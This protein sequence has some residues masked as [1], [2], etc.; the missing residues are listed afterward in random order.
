MQ[1]A[2]VFQPHE[3]YRDDQAIAADFGNQVQCGVN[4]QPQQLESSARRK[5][6]LKL[7]SLRRRRTAVAKAPAQPPKPKPQPP[8]VPRMDIDTPPQMSAAL[9]SISAVRAAGQR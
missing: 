1:A 8:A 5:I 4:S 9:K 6:L 3:P 2:I 7:A